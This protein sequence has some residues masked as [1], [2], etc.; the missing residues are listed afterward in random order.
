MEEVVDIL[1][2]DMEE[3]MVDKAWDME[4]IDTLPWDMLVWVEDMEEV[5]T[6]V[7]MVMED[8]VL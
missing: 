2:W 3:E 5:Y 7:D 1:P 8:M 6:S 4:V